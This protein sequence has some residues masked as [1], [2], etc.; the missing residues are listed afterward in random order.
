M[1]NVLCYGYLSTALKSQIAKV[2]R[3]HL[4][5]FLFAFGS[6]VCERRTYRTTSIKS[7]RES[8]RSSKEKTRRPRYVADMKRTS[9]LFLDLE[10]P[11]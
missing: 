6:V 10:R 1:G 5:F 3:I 4:R 2:A 11:F 9:A 8:R 7:E